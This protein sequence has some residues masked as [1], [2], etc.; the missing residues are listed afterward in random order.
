MRW[1][2]GLEHISRYSQATLYI[3][4]QPKSGLSAMGP[5]DVGAAKES[6][7]SDGV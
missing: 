2:V 6:S 5:A 4:C 7:S 3:L 1:Y